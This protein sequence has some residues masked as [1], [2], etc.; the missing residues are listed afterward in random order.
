MIRM[1]LGFPGTFSSVQAGNNTVR[2]AVQ[3]AML[4]MIPD[5]FMDSGCLIYYL[6]VDQAWLILFDN[7]T[8][9]C[10]RP[11]LFAQLF[12]LLMISFNEAAYFS[13]R[14]SGACKGPRMALYG[15]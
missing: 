14:S 11:S 5:D 1:I 8:A 6:L 15:R 2:V 4:L 10:E 12:N 9:G 3:A 7:V 13:I